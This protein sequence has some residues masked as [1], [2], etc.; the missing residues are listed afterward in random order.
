MNKRIIARVVFVSLIVLGA[1]LVANSRTTP[2]NN[3]GLSSGRLPACPDSPNCVST[4]A[5]DAEHRMDPIRF[6]GNAAD[7]MAAIRQTLSS[8]PRVKV[9]SETANYLHAEATS[10][11]LRFKDDL[12]FYFDDEER[13][14]H[15]RSASRVGYSDLGANRS[16]MQ[17]F[18]ERFSA[19]NE[20]SG[21]SE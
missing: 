11:I 19:T 18:V 14:I 4:Q 6:E 1:I 15:F 5:E 9:V 12:E 3:L 21:Q 2:P 13:L 10:L 16:R 17:G 20:N 8:M 7:A